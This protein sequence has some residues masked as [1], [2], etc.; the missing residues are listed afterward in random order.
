[1][2]TASLNPKLSY[3]NVLQGNERM[4]RRMET[5]IEALGPA[6]RE[7][8]NVSENGHHHIVEEC[9]RTLHVPLDRGI[10]SLRVGI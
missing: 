2:E 7:W 3:G 8:K 5:T 9:T 4:E 10:R 6:L 1:M